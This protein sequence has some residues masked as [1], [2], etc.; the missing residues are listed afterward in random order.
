FIYKG[1]T[2]KD[3]ISIDATNSVNIGPLAQLTAEA[4]GGAGDDVIS[5]KYEGQMQ[6]A[7]FL[8]A[9][10]GAGN[11]RVTAKVTLDGLS[12]GLL[13][14]PVSPNSGRAGAAVD[15]GGG[16]DKLSFEVDRSGAV[17]LK[18]ASA[19]EIDGGAGVDSCHAVGFVTGVFNCEKPF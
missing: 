16:N 7:F 2:G 5:V 18:P 3:Q 9:L 1:G 8:S 10:G 4:D 11:D 17:A 19:A 15:G 6:G 12:N 14:G 13:F